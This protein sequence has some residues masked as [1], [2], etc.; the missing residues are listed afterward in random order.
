M[1]IKLTQDQIATL[2]VFVLDTIDSNKMKNI[3]NK[4][5]NP[6]KSGHI[7]L[8]DEQ[9]LFVLSCCEDK[10]SDNIFDIY[11]LL[12]KQDCRDLIP[13]MQINYPIL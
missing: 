6:D 13:V 3:K 4:F 10:I 12:I 9:Y 2:E 8:S 11:E 7:H 1:K 5:L